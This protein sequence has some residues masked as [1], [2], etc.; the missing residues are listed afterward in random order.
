MHSGIGTYVTCL[1]DHSNQGHRS[2]C[3]ACLDI[4]GVCVFLLLVSQRATFYVSSTRR[5]LEAA[6]LVL[7][8][9]GSLWKVGSRAHWIAL[10]WPQ[11][12]WSRHG[13]FNRRKLRVATVGRNPA[14]LWYT[15]IFSLPI[16]P[17]T[18]EKEVFSFWPGE[19]F[20]PPFLQRVVIW[21]NLWLD[22][23]LVDSGPYKGQSSLHSCPF[24]QKTPSACSC[25]LSC[26]LSVLCEHKCLMWVQTDS[27]EVPLGLGHGR[28][29]WERIGMMVNFRGQFDWIEDA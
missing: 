16:M 27:S 3:L 26:F 4:G 20:L 5:L 29:V 17:S 28:W 1:R 15:V 7:D 21:S 18:V 14:Q 24:R 8:K 23:L 25:F 11:H 12:L 10:W 19:G 6:L 9:T 2:T 13:V 22:N